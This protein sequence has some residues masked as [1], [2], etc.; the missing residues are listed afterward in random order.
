MVLERLSAVVELG[1]F[2]ARG[3]LRLLIAAPNIELEMLTVFVAFPVILAA[4]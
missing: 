2:A 3:V 1:A 4:K